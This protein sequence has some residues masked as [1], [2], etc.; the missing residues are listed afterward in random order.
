M[1]RPQ[2]RPAAYCVEEEL[3]VLGP[4]GIPPHPTSHVVAQRVPHAQGPVV[5]RAMQHPVIARGQTCQAG[6]KTGALQT[7]TR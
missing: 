5:L 3:K 1:A 6:Y 2:C 7:V 4:A